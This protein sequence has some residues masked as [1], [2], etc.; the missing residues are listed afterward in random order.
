[1]DAQK[2]SHKDSKEEVAQTSFSM[3]TL[4]S[5]GLSYHHDKYSIEFSYC[6]IILNMKLGDLDYILVSITFCVTLFPHY[7]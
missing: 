2:G 5:S 4:F 1:M 7:F 6:H 3:P